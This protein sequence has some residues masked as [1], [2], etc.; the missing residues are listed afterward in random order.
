MIGLARIAP[1]TV[2]AVLLTTI[3]VTLEE[4]FVQRIGTEQTALT[5][6]T[7][8]PCIIP[9][10]TKAEEFAYKIGSAQIAQ[11]FATQLHEHTTVLRMVK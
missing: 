5:T 6:V 9:A 2:I 3:A 10:T 1:P 11:H 8:P 4:K 7:T